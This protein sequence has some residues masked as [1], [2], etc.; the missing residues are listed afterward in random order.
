MSSF[1]IGVDIVAS[2]RLKLNHVSARPLHA[3][4][5]EGRTRRAAFAPP[6]IR[7]DTA[8]YKSMRRTVIHRCASRSCTRTR[9]LSPAQFLPR[10]SADLTH[11]FQPACANTLKHRQGEMARRV[12][13]RTYR[14]RTFAVFRVASGR[15]TVLSPRTT[16]SG[17]EAGGSAAAR[18]CT[19]VGTQ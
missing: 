19:C 9:H 3:R 12:R 17:S 8:T 14:R 5:T 1:A 10:L 2:G 16:R 13:H 18:L 4:W 11:E 7:D 15:L 6:T